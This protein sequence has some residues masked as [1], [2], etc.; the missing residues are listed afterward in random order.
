MNSLDDYGVEFGVFAAKKNEEKEEVVGRLD[1]AIH[2]F[3]EVT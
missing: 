2:L 1:P 3:V